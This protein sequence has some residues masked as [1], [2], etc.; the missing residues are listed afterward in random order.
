MDTTHL[1]AMQKEL[2]GMQRSMTKKVH[3]FSCAH[4]RSVQ[5]AK[6]SCLHSEFKENNPALGEVLFALQKELSL[7]DGRQFFY[8]FLQQQELQKVCEAHETFSC[9]INQANSIVN[10][11][12][13]LLSE[14]AA[15]DSLTT[16]CIEQSKMVKFLLFSSRMRSGYVRRNL[17]TNQKNCVVC[18]S[19]TDKIFGLTTCRCGPIYDE[20]CLRKWAWK[21]F[22]SETSTCAHCRAVFDPFKD[23]FYYCGSTAEK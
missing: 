5:S 17:A 8:R 9:L 6:K 23:V 18:F 13:H 11:V 3:N 22:N 16:E 14:L 21:S 2:H 15:L 19:P 4:T 20:E 12:Q 10:H 1:H 7:I